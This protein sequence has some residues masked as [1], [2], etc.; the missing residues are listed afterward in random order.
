MLQCLLGREALLWVE[1]QQAQGECL[2][3]TGRSQQEENARAG[4][5]L[6]LAQGL[7]HGTGEARAGSDGPQV[8]LT[9]AASE[10]DDLLQ[11]VH[12]GAA[13]QYGLAGEHLAEDATEAPHVHTLAVERSS[14]QQFRC[15]VP[16]RG[17]VIREKPGASPR[18]MPVAGATRLMG[19]CACQTEV[20][21]THVA[22]GVQQYVRRFEVSVQ[23][24]CRVHILEGLKYLVGHVLHVDGL[25]HFSAYGVLQVCIHEVKNHVEVQMALGLE[26]THQPHDVFM[27]IKL[28]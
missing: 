16:A 12:G 28:L 27:A 1:E 2:G 8:L 11:L 19:V 14:Q 20:A 21:Y 5:L 17:H 13:L 24:A 26:H 4:H 18:P 6:H 10:L 15:T 25:Q 23:H 3:I 7:E 9:G 22:I